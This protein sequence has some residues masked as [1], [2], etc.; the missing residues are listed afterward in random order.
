MLAAK[1]FLTVVGAAYLFL[2]LWCTLRP[3]QTSEAVGFRLTP[4]SG[5]SEYLVVY[6]GLQLGLGLALLWPWIRPESLSYALLLSVLVHGA[7]VLFR[8]A[9]FFRYSGFQTTTYFL[10]ATEIVILAGSVVFLILNRP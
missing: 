1:I 8:T 7:I 6:G 4:G 10:A 2:A 3:E 5:Q 9:G